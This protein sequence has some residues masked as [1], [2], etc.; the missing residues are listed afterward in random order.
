M[1][2]LMYHYL[3]YT[4]FLLLLGSV[5]LSNARPRTNRHPNFMRFVTNATDFASEDYYD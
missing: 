2:K 4:V 5:P 1:S 3:L